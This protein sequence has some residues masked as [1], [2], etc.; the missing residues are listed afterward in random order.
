M[1]WTAYTPNLKLIGHLIQIWAKENEKI[2]K[3][4][5]FN[6]WAYFNK[7]HSKWQVWD[8]SSVVKYSP[9]VYDPNIIFSVMNGIVTKMK[10]LKYPNKNTDNTT[11]KMFNQM[12]RLESL[13][14][15]HECVYFKAWSTFYRWPYLNWKTKMGRLWLKKK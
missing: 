5:K 14:L 3:S 15:K 12:E 6:V 1:I 13:G 11:L 9:V 4:S 2:T 10:V 8:T 7:S